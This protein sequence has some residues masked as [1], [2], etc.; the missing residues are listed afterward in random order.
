MNFLFPCIAEA[1]MET[2]LWL[3]ASYAVGHV[4]HKQTATQ[5]PSYPLPW[6]STCSGWVNFMS[7]GYPTIHERG[8]QATNMVM[9]SQW[10]AQCSDADMDVLATTNYAF[11]LNAFDVEVAVEGIDGI[12]KDKKQ[13]CKI[14]TMIETPPE[15]V[16][17]LQDYHNVYMATM[18]TRVQGILNKWKGYC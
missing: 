8:N 17:Q 18:N 3:G 11:G 13:L 9:D 14:A 16:C 1:A 15:N 2:L 7:P 12:I 10:Q 6:P 5:C 4:I